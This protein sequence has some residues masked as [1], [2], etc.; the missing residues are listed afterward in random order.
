MTDEQVDLLHE[1][2]RAVPGTGQIVEIGS[3]R[4]RSTIVLAASA[5]TSAQFVAIEPHAGND[6][7]PQELD[8]YEAEAADDHESFEANLRGAGVRERVRHV[9]AF[10]DDAVDQVTGEID[11][12]FI[13]GAHRFGPARADI[14]T[15]G[16][17]V[18]PGGRMLIHDSFASVGV[19]LAQLAELFTSTAWS[20]EGRASSL[21]S[22]RRVDL[23]T[24][25][26]VRNLLRQVAELPWFVRNVVVKALILAR[27]GRLTRYLDHP[28]PE[29]WPH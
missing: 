18:A 22:Y 6:R 13:D 7:G 3:F 19:T 29:V 27:L 12:L 28:D 10:S 4:G 8:G 26:R 16:A 14:R 25:G 17:R 5:P 9:R 11:L 20:Y 2:A 21:T 23:D 24:R 1:S 15:W